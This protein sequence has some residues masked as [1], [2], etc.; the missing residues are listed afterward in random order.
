MQKL[1]KEESELQAKIKSIIEGEKIFVLGNNFGKNKAN[2]AKLFGLDEAQVHLW[3]SKRDSKNNTKP[4]K[5]GLMPCRFETEN[6]TKG[7]NIGNVYTMLGTEANSVLVIIGE[8]VKAKNGTVYIERHIKWTRHIY[9][10][11]LTRGMQNCYIYC[12]DNGMRE[13][14]SG[15]ESRN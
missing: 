2:A 3:K 7:I 12:I 14:L 4:E 6:K 1:L 8:E 15:F 13:Y 10:I 5:V 11:L 9:R